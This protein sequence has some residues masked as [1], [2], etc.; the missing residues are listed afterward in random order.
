MSWQCYILEHGQTVYQHPDV[1]PYSVV[2]VNKCLEEYTASIFRVEVSQV[3]KK[4][5]LYK[6]EP[7]HTR[8]EDS[9]ES[10]MGKESGPW[11]ASG[12]EWP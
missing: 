2:G 12:N 4:G 9:S 8:Q 7:I 1:T 11:W 3:R 5:R 10:G 6:G